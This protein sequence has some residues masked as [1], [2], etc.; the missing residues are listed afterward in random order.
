[1]CGIN[2]V[3][4]ASYVVFANESSAWETWVTGICSRTHRVLDPAS[5]ADLL[6]LRALPRAPNTAT[7]YGTVRNFLGRNPDS[8]GRIGL[9]PGTTIT[10]S[11]PERQQISADG[12]GAFRVEGLQ[13]GKYTV[14]AFAPEG[15]AAIPPVE[16]SV[17][18]K[19]CAEIQFETRVDGHIRGHLYFS[20]GRQASD[21]FMIA[22]NVGM[23]LGENFYATTA[24][25]GAFDFGPLTPGTYSF[26]VNPD[27]QSARG[28]SQKA[29]FPRNIVLGS[30]EAT[31]DL[32]FVLPPDRP[33][34]SVPV[35]VFVLDRQGRAVA[36]AQVLPDDATWT[37]YHS[38]DYR[39]D[40][41]G[42][43]TLLLRKGSY[44]DIW[45][46]VSRAPGSQQ[47][48]EPIG[49]LAGQAPLRITL[50]MSHDFGN[51]AQ[52]KRPHPSTP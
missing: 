44:Y 33:D 12:D 30:S 41:G 13:P 36:N 27:G 51:C 4:G 49:V 7:I 25:D 10:I 16:V 5:D 26:G 47:C 6:W 48:A 29:M 52:F 23:R 39:T 34:P 14:A 11:G 28:Y 38:G 35:E 31:Q 40:A 19:G 22:R 45:A 37:D 50:R 32:R 9:L 43:A 21:I 8:T 46:Y 2:F 24:G 20:D 3:E 15:Y 42:R 17:E 1:M 18:P